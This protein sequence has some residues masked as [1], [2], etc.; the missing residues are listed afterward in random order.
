MPHKRDKT[1]TT[2]RRAR[3]GS[4]WGL[5]RRVAKKMGK[6]E[7]LV[8]GVKLGVVK[9]AKVAKAIA[10]ERK[11]MRKEAATR[12]DTTRSQRVKRQRNCPCDH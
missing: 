4:E 2:Q 6:S 1:Q 7:S 11:L 9:S 10:H 8:S 5:V 3:P 12:E